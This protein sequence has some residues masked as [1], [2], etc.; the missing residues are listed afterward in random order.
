MKELFLRLPGDPDSISD[1]IELPNGR[2]ALLFMKGFRRRQNDAI[3]AVL[4]DD[5]L[6]VCAADG[7]GEDQSNKPLDDGGEMAKWVVEFGIK[8]AQSQAGSIIDPLRI[9]SDIRYSINGRNPLHRGRA[10]SLCVVIDGRAI[11]AHK[12]GDPDT[13]KGI[14][15]YPHPDLLPDN[16]YYS[17]FKTWWENNGR[18]GVDPLE[19]LARFNQAKGAAILHGL[20][21]D[22]GIVRNVHSGMDTDTGDAFLLSRITEILLAPNE[23]FAGG[24]DGLKNVQLDAW[25]R[26]NLMNAMGPQN[27]LTDLW[28]ELERN[29]G[30]NACGVAF[31]CER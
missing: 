13:R 30:E 4:I 19:T 27:Y 22:Q 23:R 29:N 26:Q 8:S 16:D 15:V 17:H 21:K 20:T 5:Q 7:A 24:S 25:H 18:S 3:A 28:R 12:V 11:R 2:A 14:E 31:F 10:S 6:V 9:Q 1:P